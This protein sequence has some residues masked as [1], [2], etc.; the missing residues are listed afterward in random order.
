VSIPRGLRMT[1]SYARDYVRPGPSHMERQGLLSSHTSLAHDTTRSRKLDAI[2][3]PDALCKPRRPLE[4]TK[5]AQASRAGAACPRPSALR[6]RPPPS[7]WWRPHFTGSPCRADR[8]RRQ[9]PGCSNLSE[10]PSCRPPR[11]RRRPRRSQSRTAWSTS[12]PS[13]RG[14]C[15]PRRRRCR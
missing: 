13:R 11:D 7:P 4:A 10:A 1:G 15:S 8:R 6:C 9:R 5:R 3:A 2:A 14:A 12:C